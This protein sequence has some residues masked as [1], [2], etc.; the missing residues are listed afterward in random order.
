MGR[1]MTS[2]SLC[3][4]MV[5]TLAQ[6]ARDMGSI[7]MTSPLPIRVKLRHLLCVRVCIT[8]AVALH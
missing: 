6:N 8:D 3:G 7:E 5:R 1:V 4:E 2:G